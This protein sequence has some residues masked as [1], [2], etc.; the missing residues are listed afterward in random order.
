MPAVKTLLR[1]APA[2]VFLVAASWAGGGKSSSP[3]W[4]G[5]WRGEGGE[6]VLIF[7]SATRLRFNSE[8]RTYSRSGGR[9]LVQEEGGVVAYPYV[10]EGGQLKI[11]F[12]GEGV[13]VFRRP[14]KPAAVKPAGGQ[15]Y[16]V[17]GSFCSYSGSSNYSGSYSSSR[18]AFFDGRG[19]F[20]TGGESSFNTTLYDGGTAGGASSNAGPGGRYRVQGNKV[21]LTLSDGTT[22]VA[23]VN[24]RQSDGSVS[25]LMYEG[26]LYAKGLC[27]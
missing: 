4:L 20:A 1:A 5:E 17:Q 19:R 22:G 13:V 21:F 11:S 26:T 18:K 9:F 15:E 24:M 2:L 12:P 8:V 27:E 14:A 16:L 6:P 3:S 23:T 10:L 25:E 7:D